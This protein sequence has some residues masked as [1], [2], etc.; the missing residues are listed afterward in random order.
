MPRYLGQA[1]AIGAALAGVP[2]VRVVPDPPQTPM[3]HVLLTT[4][5]ATVDAAVRRHAAD[6]VWTIRGASATADP[7]VL[8]FELPVGDATCALQPGEAAALIA[9][10]VQPV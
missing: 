7:A 3:L 2:G 6:G 5:E 1:R 10:L 4:D 8:R 9:A